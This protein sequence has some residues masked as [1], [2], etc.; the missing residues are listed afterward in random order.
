MAHDDRLAVVLRRQQDRSAADSRDPLVRRLET[1]LHTTRASLRTKL[2]ELTQAREQL[3]SLGDQLSVSRTEHTAFHD[4]LEMVHA[5]LDHVRH[6]LGETQGDHAELVAVLSHE[7][8]NPLMIIGCGLEILGHA[9]PGGELAWRAL[10]VLQRQHGYM[11][12]MIEE[13]LDISRISHGKIQLRRERLDLG[14]LVRHTV[15]DHRD[16]FRA[17]GIA[18]ELAA[19]PGAIS[20]HGDPTRLRQAVGNLLHNA[21]KFTP[22]GGAVTVSVIADAASTQAILRVQDT[23]RGIDPEILPRVFEPFIQAEAAF[24]RGKGGLGLGLAVV[25]G[26]VEAHGGT[27]TA[28]SAGHDQG[29]TFTLSFPLATR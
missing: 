10:E 3:A 22:R 15:E 5:E 27:A 8:R 14:E 1:E 11:S 29:A 13:L 28:A 23:G 19:A 17:V 4:E 24:D 7:L 26:V 21:T 25:R 9:E 2:E 18:L 12:R 20:I 16:V 6:E